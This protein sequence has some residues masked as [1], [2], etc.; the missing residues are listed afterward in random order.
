[1]PT[2]MEPGALKAWEQALSSWDAWLLTFVLVTV[3]PALGYLRSRRLSR[4]GQAVSRHT[5]LILYARIICVQWSLVGVL[6]LV[7]TRHGLSAGDVGERMGNAW[8][9]RWT[10]AAV[11]TVAAGLSPLVLWR[12]RRARPERLAHSFGR[13][14]HIAP[15]FGTELTVFMFVCLTAGVCEELLYRGWLINVFGVAAGSVW[16]GVAFSTAAFGIGH[17]YQGVKGMLRAAFV[18]LQL[19]LLFVLVR[20]LIPGQALHAAADL[21]AGF[22]SATAV[23]RLNAAEAAGMS[24]DEPARKPA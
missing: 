16:L 4:D 13:L 2:T 18:G 22:A 8:L 1:M 7:L 14:R 6:L 19:A 17:A 12:V 21:I 10:T 23:S 11:L 9:T 20:S 24:A 3:V 5:K 15:A